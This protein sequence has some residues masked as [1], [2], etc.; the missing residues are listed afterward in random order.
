MEVCGFTKDRND[1]NLTTARKVWAKEFQQAA[2]CGVDVVSMNGHVKN[3]VRSLGMDTF[4]LKDDEFIPREFMVGLRSCVRGFDPADYKKFIQEITNENLL[5][6]LLKP[7]R[8]FL[9]AAASSEAKL[10]SFMAISGPPGTGKTWKITQELIAGAE[11]GTSGLAIAPSNDLRNQYLKEMLKQIEIM[12]SDGKEFPAHFIFIGPDEDGLLDD[13][14]CTFVEHV[15]YPDENKSGSNGKDPSQAGKPVIAIGCLQRICTWALSWKYQAN[16]VFYDEFGLAQWLDLAAA[17]A[18]VSPTGTLKTMGDVKQCGPISDSKSIIVVQKTEAGQILEPKKHN[19]DPLLWDDFIAAQ[20]CVLH[21]LDQVFRKVLGK[22]PDGK[23]ALRKACFGDALS[24]CRRCHPALVR[25]IRNISYDGSE[26]NFKFVMK[27]E[28]D[29]ESTVLEKLNVRAIMLTYS[30]Q[31][32][33]VVSPE[34]PG[35]RFQGG[36]GKAAREMKVKNPFTTSYKCDAELKAMED[37]RLALEYL[38]PKRNDI[39]SISSYALQADRMKGRRSTLMKAQGG[40][41]SVTMFGITSYAAQGASFSAEDTNVV[42]S[43]AIDLF[44]FFADRS[45]YIQSWQTRAFNSGT[46]S[47]GFGRLMGMWLDHR[48][49]IMYINQIVEFLKNDDKESALKVVDEINAAIKVTLLP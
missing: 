37:V 15:P 6:L 12:K 14:N 8:Y 13:H 30:S 10:T 47:D 27:P 46:T 35:A 21:K 40:Q 42:V 26:E 22:H 19:E 48:D 32:N 25:L 39:L 33:T 20:M 9:S 29:F 18:L 16:L 43:R 38:L 45:R 11:N 41:A 31:K 28:T 3:F 36:F 34:V 1:V 44:L 5:K 4:N 24:G 49:F 7:E 23:A 2:R 17:C